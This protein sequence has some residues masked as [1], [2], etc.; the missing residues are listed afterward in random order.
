MYIYIHIQ[1][2]IYYIEQHIYICAYLHIY[3]S[4]Y[5]LYVS[6]YLL[7]ISTYLHVRALDVKHNAYRMNAIHVF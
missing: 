1:A 7:Y 4:I 6:T 3:V 2:Y 5:L